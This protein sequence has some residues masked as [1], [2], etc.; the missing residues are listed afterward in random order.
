MEH[1]PFVQAVIA[2][3]ASIDD[4]DDHV[5]AWHE[6]LQDQTGLAQYLGMSDA[7]Y[8]RWIGDAGQLEIII[9]EIRAQA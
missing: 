2:G 8:A 4:V 3:E 7:Q 6:D 1:K 9:D 5:E